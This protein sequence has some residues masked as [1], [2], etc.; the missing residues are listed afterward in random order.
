MHRYRFFKKY[1]KTEVTTLLVVE[2]DSRKRERQL[3]WSR[4]ILL[5]SVTGCYHVVRM[6]ENLSELTP[7]VKLATWYE[8]SFQQY[9]AGS[10][11]PFHPLPLGWWGRYCALTHPGEKGPPFFTPARSRG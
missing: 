7:S 8:F 11:A 4:P 1:R 3:L 6:I 5:E 2:L 10:P 9:A